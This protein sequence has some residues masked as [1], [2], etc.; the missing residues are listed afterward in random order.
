MA[1]QRALRLLHPLCFAQRSSQTPR[2]FSLPLS[3][4]FPIRKGGKPLEASA[5]KN[6]GQHGAYAIAVTHGT[7]LTPLRYSLE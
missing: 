1:L 5:Q 7:T 2:K 3:L 6:L 4:A